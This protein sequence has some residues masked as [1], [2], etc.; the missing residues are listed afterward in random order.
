MELKLKDKVA[1]VFAA[2]KGLGKGAALALANEGCKLAICSRN[3]EAIEQAA[4]EISQKTKTEVFSQV[5]DVQQKDDI[6]G[7]IKA[8][9]I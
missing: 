7:F 4:S 3:Q 8:V 9:F 6:E 2:S 5:A 1:V